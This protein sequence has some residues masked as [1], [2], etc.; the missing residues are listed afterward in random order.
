MRTALQKW[1]VKNRDNFIAEGVNGPAGEAPSYVLPNAL[2][3]PE[4]RESVRP[5]RESH[6]LHAL[7]AKHFQGR[8]YRELLHSDVGVNRQ[9]FWHKDL[10]CD[11][12]AEHQKTDPWTK[13]PDGS[14]YGVL[15]VSLYLQDHSLDSDGLFVIPGSHR[16]LS[17]KRGTLAVPKDA[18]ITLNPGSGD[19]VIIDQRITH[20]GPLEV[21]I[22]CEAD[23]LLFS[24]SIGEDNVFSDAH[25][26]GSI[27]RQKS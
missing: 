4:I 14:P 25:E 5:L 21:D 24:F 16:R 26:M 12:W 8:N 1:R 6:A 22:R 9:V 18:S 7:L 17:S 10:L 3:Y 19:I 20:R 23:R 11:K 15:K 13:S 2:D 27:L